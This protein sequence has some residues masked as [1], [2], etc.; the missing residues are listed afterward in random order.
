MIKINLAR[1]KREKPKRAIA[2][3]ITAIKQLKVQDLLKAG[4]EYYVGLLA[5]L[6]LAGLFGYYWKVAKDRDKLKTELNRLNTEKAKLQSKA[7]KLSE[8]KKRVE[9]SIAKLKKE[10]QDVN[11]GKDIILGLKAYYEPFNS[12]FSFYTSYVPRTSWVTSYK[13]GISINQQSLKVEIEVSS[14]DYQSLSSYGNSLGKDS[15]KIMLSKVERRLNPHGFEYYS[16]KFATE[17]D[18]GGGR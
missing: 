14:L 15:K 10:I 11:R 8:D 5:W 7:R 13:Q 9:E 12:G 3:D 6:C 4:G 16:V 1:V 18:L 2:F 17:K